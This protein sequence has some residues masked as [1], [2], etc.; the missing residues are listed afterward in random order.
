MAIKDQTVYRM[1]IKSDLRNVARVEKVTEKIANHMHFS[2][3]EK[4]SLAI[5]V[6]EIVGNAIVHGNKRDKK[7]KVTIDF[8]YKN[9]TIV[10][11]IQDEGKGF[12]VNEIANPLEPENL[13]KESGRGIFIVRALMDSVEFKNT[14]A[15]TQVQL[16]KTT[17]S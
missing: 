4:D 6:T 7:K 15:G 10:V 3:E 13:L 17:Q 5:A 1:V 9:K 16:K 12:D 8:E 11:T 14:G 2:D